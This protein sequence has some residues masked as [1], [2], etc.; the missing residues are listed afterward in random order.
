MQFAPLALMAAG[1]IFKGVAGLQ[2]GKYNRSIANANARNALSE[3]DAQ[4]T[5]IRD[6]A[7]IQL[8]RQIGAQGESGFT[9][10]TGSAVDD[11]VESQTNVE[12]D[13]MDVMRTA[14]SRSDAYRLSGASAYSEG[15]NDL[16]S[17]LFGAAGSVASGLQD[18]ATAKSSSGY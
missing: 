4:A 8:G 11:L 5:R 9:V 15:K 6:L 18:Y 13:A 12:L 1:S 14:R 16:L 10:G 2:A 3:G 17:G 7:R